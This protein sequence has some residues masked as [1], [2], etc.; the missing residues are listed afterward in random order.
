VEQVTDIG[1]EAARRF[2]DSELKKWADLVQT[3]GIEMR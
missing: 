3:H 2:I 1:P